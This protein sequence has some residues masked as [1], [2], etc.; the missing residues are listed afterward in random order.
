MVCSRGFKKELQ[1]NTYF[2][3]ITI[4]LCKHVIQSL[5][6]TLY[7]CQYRNNKPARDAVEIFFLN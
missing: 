1:T 2:R 4:A 3:K 5:V 6:G 7:V